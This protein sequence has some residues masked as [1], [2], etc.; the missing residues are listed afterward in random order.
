VAPEVTHAMAYPHLSSPLRIGSRTLPNRIVMGPHQTQLGLA[1]GL[2][3]EALGGYLL[4]RA[5]GGAAM[6]VVEGGVTT[7]NSLRKNNVLQAY[8]AE[9]V[10]RWSPIVA[11][12]RAVGTPM[13]AQLLHSGRQ[14]TGYSNLD[15]P[16]W[17]PSPIACPFFN[18][19]PK[20]MEADDLRA[21]VEDFGSCAARMRDAGF[22]GVEIHACHG[23]LLN[24]FLS[25]Y[26]NKRTDAYGGA[27]ENR[28]RLLLEVVHRVRAEL[29]ADRVVGVRL[30]SRELVPNGLDLDETV[31]IAVAL[32]A[33][34]EVDYLSISQGVRETAEYIRAPMFME[35]A[36]AA[37][38]TAQIKRAVTIPVLAVGRM[39]GPEI[40]ERV[41]EQGQADGIVMTRELIADPDYPRKALEGRAEEIRRCVAT[42]DC[43]YSVAN[44]YSLRC[45]Y[46]AEI[47]REHLERLR[48]KARGRRVLVVGAGPAGLEAA[49]V[50]AIR[51][52][53]VELADRATHLGGALRLASQTPGRQELVGVVS[54]YETA[55]ARLN[56][57][58]HLGADM[59]VAD[60]LAKAPDVVIVA[61]G[62][63]PVLPPSPLVPDI[64]VAPG[65]RLISYVEAMGASWDAGQRVVLIDGDLGALGLSI[66]DWLA[67]RKVTVTLV[68]RGAAPGVF[69]DGPTLK[70]W[71]KRLC[72]R[73]VTLH[74]FRSLKEVTPVDAVL[75]YGH[76]GDI[77]RVACDAVVYAQAR[78]AD[79]ALYHAVREAASRDGRT[80]VL[81]A[82][83]CVAPR[84][85]M[86]A[87]H[88]GFE[89]GCSI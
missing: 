33:T 41:L 46:N 12:V 40:A 81:R 78:R 18:E 3:G 14:A 23:Y 16:L 37:A 5:R 2:P 68:T 6:L 1:D 71:L 69:L 57:T 74:P 64:A 63:A 10:E 62:S 60:V 70:M 89:I 42:N 32:E 17:A 45:V 26:T 44:G 52:H 48:P 87:V 8:R 25:P 65:A 58:V 11:A 50:A 49:R 77:E 24:E 72:T 31:P 27:L 19:M 53:E 79:D 51:G 30:E 4:A 66:A 36:Y 28:M 38:F 56:V 84:S 13:I 29:G 82:G 88:D 86:F 76:T 54:Y 55:L 73:G 59:E 15:R 80:R 47:G 83:D 22:D 21:V 20:E 75:S 9:C 67:E 43:V 85:A 61:T 7:P 34:G 39:A 35:P